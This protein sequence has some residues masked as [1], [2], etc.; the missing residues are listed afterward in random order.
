MVSVKGVAPASLVAGRADLLAVGCG[1]RASAGRHGD[2]D[3]ILR[4]QARRHLSSADIREWR[5]Q[6]RRDRL[7]GCAPMTEPAANALLR[8]SVAQ[9]CR[10]AATRRD[11][12]RVRRARGARRRDARGRRRGAQCL[13]RAARDRDRSCHHRAA[14]AGDGACARQAGLK[15]V[16]TGIEHGTVTV[17]ADGVPFEVTTLRRDVETFGRHATVAFTE[18]WEEDARRRDFTLNALYAGSDGDAV[19]SA[20]RLCRSCRRPRAL[21]RRCRSAHQGG[22]SPHPAL[23]PLQR[24]LRQGP[25]R[26]GRAC[27]LRAAARR[28]GSAFGGTGRRRVAQIARGA[29]SD[30]GGRGAVRLRAA[31]AAARR[32][33]ALDALRADWSPPKRRSVL[34]P[35]RRSG[36]RRLPCSWRR[37]P[38]GLPRA[39]ASPMPN[40]RCL[41]SAPKIMPPAELPDRG[42]GQAGALPARALRF[43]APC[44]ARLRRTPACR[45]TIGAGGRRCGLPTAG[46]RRSSRC[47]GPTSWRLALRRARRSARCCGGSKP[48]GSP[49][50]SPL[51]RDELLARGAS[52]SRKSPKQDR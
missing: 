42:G 45:P 50:A 1:M 12:A 20:R 19:R 27:R 52:L 14:G 8:A 51:S 9:G 17:V 48:N 47:A 23:L 40:R 32:R 24:L 41:R 4:R 22:L 10:V 13:A 26:C 39:C 29:S 21:H 34:R 3:P 37:T 16:P 35:T 31:D 7:S 25:A 36:L 43:E 15:A 46:R 18:D 49:A 2:A 6:A 30:A 11:G 33:A 44:A 38:S 5:R 28:A